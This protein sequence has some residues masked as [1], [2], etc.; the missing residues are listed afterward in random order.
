MSSLMRVALNSAF[1]AGLLQEIQ[2]Y[3]LKL[4]LEKFII[5][6]DNDQYSILNKLLKYCLK[7]MQSLKYLDS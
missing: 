5:L 3:L 4:L 1:I 2:M 6:Y 7:I